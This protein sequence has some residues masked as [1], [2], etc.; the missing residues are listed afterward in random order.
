MHKLVSDI[1]QSAT[2]FMEQLNPEQ[3]NAMRV[4]IVN[5]HDGVNV[6]KKSVLTVY[7]SAE[8]DAPKHTYTITELPDYDSSTD[9]ISKTS[10][11]TDDLNAMLD[12]PICSTEA[13]HS[14]IPLPVNK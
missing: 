1:M 14:E 11:Q 3:I 4:Q 13:P 6:Q 8:S 7:T 12:A 10:Y 2:V 5:V 9:T